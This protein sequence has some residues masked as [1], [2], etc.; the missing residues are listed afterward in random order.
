MRK[1]QPTSEKKYE[2]ED[3]YARV[4]LLQIFSH[5]ANPNNCKSYSQ[6]Y[7]ESICYF[8][9]DISSKVSFEAINSLSR[10]PWEKLVSQ[11]IKPLPPSSDFS[12]LSLFF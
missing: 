1:F 9:N 7:Y 6:E 2:I 10:F 5:F 4:Y 8:I 3:V 12:V 11:E